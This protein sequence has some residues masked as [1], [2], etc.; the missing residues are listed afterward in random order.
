[1]RGRDT[2][3]YGFVSWILSRISFCLYLLW[4]VVPDHRIVNTLGFSYFPSK[5]WAIAFPQF[6]FVTFLFAVVAYWALSL[7][8]TPA[9]SSYTL[10]AGKPV[11]GRQEGRLLPCRQASKSKLSLL[12]MMHAEAS[13]HGVSSIDP[14]FVLLRHTSAHSGLLGRRGARRRRRVDREGRILHLH[15]PAPP[16]QRTPI[17]IVIIIK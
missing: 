16:D 13:L 14:R 7:T 4:A 2:E 11:L 3:V 15:S 12:R 9:L 10:V 8:N 17:L 1:M 6:I 5:Y